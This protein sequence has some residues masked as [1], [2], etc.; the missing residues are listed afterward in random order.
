MLPVS[1]RCSPMAE[2][3]SAL[4]MFES[5]LL[6]VR[7]GSLST[8]AGWSHSWVTPTRSSPAPQKWTIS[9]ALGRSEATRILEPFAGVAQQG[10]LADVVHGQHAHQVPRLDD[11]Q[12]PEAALLQEAGAIREE[13]GVRRDG[14]EVRLHKVANARVP[15][16]GVGCGH[17]L[18]ARDHAYKPSVLVH[19]GE[20]LLEAVDH[21]VEDLAEGVVGADGLKPGPRA[22]HVRDQKAA[23]QL[24]L[25]DHLGLAVGPEEDKDGD[26]GEEEVTA[27]EPD[28]EEGQGEK[29][30]YSR[31]D[32]R[33]PHG[34]HTGCEQA[35]QHPP[36]VHREGGQHVEDHEGY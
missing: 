6:L 18:V 28:Q 30:P 7:W 15:L 5:I 3:I 36:A 8:P 10:G 23:R 1:V 19:Y 21:R 27:E 26:Q 31:G 20:V 35:P 2:S 17:D 14:G 4:V 25:S 33:R 12:G 29:L 34:S 16:R 9:V 22:H 11:G 32:V 24:P 13:V